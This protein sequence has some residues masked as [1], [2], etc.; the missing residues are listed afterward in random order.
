MTGAMLVDQ[1][2][3]DDQDDFGVSELDQQLLLSAQ[4]EECSAQA[5]E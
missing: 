5:E 1:E 3:E 4:E 2:E